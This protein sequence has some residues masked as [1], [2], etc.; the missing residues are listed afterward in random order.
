MNAQKKILF[1]HPNFPAQ[2]KCPLI[3]LGLQNI[4]DVRF[5]CFTDYGNNIKGIKKYKIKG[6]KGQYGLE[7]NCRD[8][9]SKSYFRAES[10]RFA[11]KQ[12]QEQGWNP[13]IVISHT[14]W[15]CGIYVKEIW[16]DTN[17]IGYVEWWFQPQ[18]ALSV[19]AEKHPF[20]IHNPDQQR[21][22][23]IRN[24]PIG[25]ELC[26]AD[27][28]I[29]PTNWQKSQL[30]TTLQEKC[31]IVRDGIDTEFF[32]PR[33]KENSNE[34]YLS[35]GSRGMEPIR[36]FKEFIKVIPPLLS[37][38]PEIKIRIAGEDKI[39]Y[40]GL[41]PSPYQ[42]WGTWAKGVLAKHPG[43]RRVEWMGLL[44]RDQ[45][46]SWLQNSSCH[47][48]LSQPYVCSW[49][50]LDAISAGIPI[51][52]NKTPPVMEYVS[53]MDGVITV[54]DTSVETLA[55]AISKVYRN[56]HKLDPRLIRRRRQA[57]LDELSEAS[58][59]RAWGRVTG[60]DLDTDH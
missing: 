33:F 29:A 30:P 41:N 40:G 27:S 49:S 34:L 32:L 8:E 55:L 5:L 37:K 58:S 9:I 60:L 39:C 4:H 43:Y 12:F 56:R 18:S 15:G 53:N 16:P 13:D 42:S 45:Y 31:T 20:L 59:R 36:C 26:N 21:K 46:L 1:L 47:I 54:K 52:T 17:F 57:A 2:F 14:G 6:E 10:Y 38:F 35:Y 24:Q 48:Y 11:F 7:K 44:P 3:A 51:I 50:L 23:W 22:L 28:I 19:I 25:F